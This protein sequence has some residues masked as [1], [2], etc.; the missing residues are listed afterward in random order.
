MVQCPGIAALA[1]ALSVQLL[2]LAAVG[3]TQAATAAGGL[4]S[5]LP[6]TEVERNHGQPADPS[7]VHARRKA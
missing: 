1:L 5:W 3:P 4:W 6:A 2:H 7:V